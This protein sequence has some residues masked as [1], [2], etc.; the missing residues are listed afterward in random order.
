MM[1]R[2]GFLEFTGGI[3]DFLVKVDQALKKGEDSRSSS[4]GS[5]RFLLLPLRFLVLLLLQYETYLR[6]FR[7]GTF[8]RNERSCRVQ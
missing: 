5:V 6:T 8:W 1:V 4:M 2:G 7:R 3:G